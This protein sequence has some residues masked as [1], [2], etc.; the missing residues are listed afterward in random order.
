MNYYKLNKLCQLRKFID[1]K[2]SPFLFR[3]LIS[4]QLDYCNI[5][6]FGILKYLIQILQQLV[7]FWY[8]ILQ[9]GPISLVY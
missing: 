3:S 8:L 2:A 9:R 6:Y 1:Y 7:S 4:S 5:L